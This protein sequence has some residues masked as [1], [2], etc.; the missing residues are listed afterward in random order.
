MKTG[1]I[2]FL[3]KSEKSEF[4]ALDRFFVYQTD[5][6]SG[7][8]FANRTLHILFSQFL[9]IKLLRHK[10]SVVLQSSLFFYLEILLVTNFGSVVF[11]LMLQ[12]SSQQPFCAPYNSMKEL[13]P[14]FTKVECLPY[15]LLLRS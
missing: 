5:M 4:R 11:K 10:Y 14:L 8:K 6:Y 12:N 3:L 2:R 9:A 1:T 15:C 13:F 7:N